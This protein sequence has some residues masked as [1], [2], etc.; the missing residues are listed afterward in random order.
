MRF[1]KVKKKKNIRLWNLWLLCAHPLGEQTDNG[2]HLAVYDREE[3]RCRGGALS[4]RTMS[5]GTASRGACR[6]VVEHGWRERGNISDGHAGWAVQPLVVCPPA[7][8]GAGL[9]VG[10]RGVRLMAAESL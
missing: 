10:P 6:R 3:E 5:M 7:Q 4:G 8:S 9:R 1:Q 2:V